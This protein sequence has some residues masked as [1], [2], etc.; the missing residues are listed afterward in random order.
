LLNSNATV[1]VQ[2]LIRKSVD[3]FERL[4]DVRY[5]DKLGDLLRKLARFFWSFAAKLCCLLALDKPSYT[6]VVSIL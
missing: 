2:P 1:L 5:A 4:C 3:P 6:Y